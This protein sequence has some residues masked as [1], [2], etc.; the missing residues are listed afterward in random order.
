VGN[1]LVS[2]AET[3]IAGGPPRANNPLHVWFVSNHSGSYW[4]LKQVAA[5]LLQK[6]KLVV[7]FLQSRT[8][9]GAGQDPPTYKTSNTPYPS[10]PSRYNEL[11]I[12]QRTTV[13]C[14][15]EV[16]VAK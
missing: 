7:V 2:Y 6:Y 14:I 15:T 8:I 16:K 12:I 10:S 3:Y 4:L 11:E 13:L 1:D 9:N 5:Y